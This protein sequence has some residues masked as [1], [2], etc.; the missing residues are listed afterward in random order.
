MSK[1]LIYLSIESDGSIRENEDRTPLHVLSQQWQERREQ[2][3]ELAIIS[4]PTP[5]DSKQKKQIHKTLNRFVFN[6]QRYAVSLLPGETNLYVGEVDPGILMLRIGRDGRVHNQKKEAAGNGE[7]LNSPYSTRMVGG[8]LFPGARIAQVKVPD[9]MTEEEEFAVRN[10]LANLEWEGRRYAIAGGTGGAKD[11]KFYCVEQSSRPDFNRQYQNWAEAAIAYFGI[12]V[13]ECDKALIEKVVRIRI[14]NDGE[15]GTN[16]SRPYFKAELFKELNLDPTEVPQFRLA[17]KVEVFQAKGTAKWMSAETAAHP[18]VDADIVLPASCIKP[19]RSDLVGKVIEVPVVLGVRDVSRTDMVYKGSYTVLQH[20]SWEVIE[21]EIIAKC[22]KEIDGLK[23]GFDT[24]EHKEL[25]SL[26]GGDNSDTGYFRVVEGCLAS[27]RDGFISRHPHVHNGIKKLLAQWAYRMLTGGGMRMPGRMLIDDGYL[28]VEDGKL[29]SGSDWIEYNSSISDLPGDRNLCVRYPIRMVEDLLPMK[30]MSRE[31]VI[32]SLV[33]E[34]G[35]SLAL[36]N[37]VFDT[38]LNLHGTYTIH[39]KRA[40]T[41]GGDYDGDCVAVITSRDYPMFVDY[42]F[43][44]PEY[45]QPTKTKG[46]PVVSPMMKIGSIAFKAMGNTVGQITNAMSA[47][48][49]AGRLDLA[50]LLYPELQKSLDSLKHNT[51]PDMK[52]V[53][54]VMEQVGKPEW[55]EIDKKLKSVGDLPKA[56]KSLSDSDVIGKMYNVLYTYLMDVIGV[57]KP[58]SEFKSIFEG[59]IG[60]KKVPTKSMYFECRRIKE[61]FG[62]TMTQGFKWLTKKKD[63]V[64]AAKAEV[65]AARQAGDKIE[66]SI[67]YARLREAEGTYLEATRTHRFLTSEVRRAIGVWGNSKPQN[68]QMSWAAAM[69]DVVCKGNGSG[70]ILYH[71]FPQQFADAVAGQTGGE[72]VLVDQTVEDWMLVLN[73]TG[74]QLIRVNR[75]STQVPLY[76]RYASKIT[77]ENGSIYD[78]YQWTRISRDLPELVDDEEGSLDYYQEFAAA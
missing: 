26:I 42:C 37:T 28:V 60:L 61:F 48:V 74:D 15:L 69:N 44:L 41:V 11:G 65:K 59:L 73:S 56:I 76:R 16:D 33:N 66:V 17:S 55:L 67:A 45:Q 75:D 54:S 36:A 50:R 68:D 5:A 49:A 72:K 77:A 19:K 32:N 9:R 46:T 78:G 35:L 30:N 3:S 29:Y 25:L 10:T 27:D 20:A 2:G 39:S 62:S 18:D 8:R 63:A 40:A 64:D 24:D 71:A 38:Q 43:G 52:L 57:P 47:A 7:K 58:I 1:K 6:G 14:V 12:L 23:K 4:A 34:Q 31:E 21:G 51:Q 13:S 22:K 70:A 53:A